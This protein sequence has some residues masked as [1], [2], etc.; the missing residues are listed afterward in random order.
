M[1][2]IYI[3]CEGATE[4]AFV[5]NLLQ[6]YFIATDV[7]VSPI[8][9][10]T[11]TKRGKKFT[12][13]VS[14]FESF[15]SEVTRICKE[16]AHESVTMM[17]DYYALPEDFLGQ[18]LVEKDVYK[19]VKH[20]ERQI[21]Q[22]IGMRNFRACLSVHEFEALLFSFPDSFSLAEKS[23][24]PLIKKIKDDFSNPEFINNS[25]K[26]APSKRIYACYPR[27]SKT[28]DGIIIAKDIGI[29]RMLAE[30]KHFK[31]WIE[32]IVE[33]GRRGLKNG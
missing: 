1:R 24:V 30:C 21:E 28:R 31:E 20:I 19:K 2:N 27:Y 33:S 5:N 25:A 6:D 14:N 22:K 17:F 16:H 12:G 10:R 13:G 15:K 32:W 26:T 11:S 8:V 18:D 3:Y 9:C 23:M 29:Q 4:E 7:C